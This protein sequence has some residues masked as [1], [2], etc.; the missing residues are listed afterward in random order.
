M[1]DMLDQMLISRRECESGI[2]RMDAIIRQLD[3]PAREL[4][5]IARRDWARTAYLIQSRIEQ[6]EG[7]TP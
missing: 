1:S 6:M 5:A 4:A 7:A 3:G 2:D